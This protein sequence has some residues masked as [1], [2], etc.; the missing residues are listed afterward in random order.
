MSCELHAT[1]LSGGVIPQKTQT[2][3]V[4]S[5][6]ENQTVTPDEGYL[7]S[8]VAV[9]GMPT[10]TAS[11]TPTESAQTVTPSEGKLLSEVSVGAIPSQYHNTSDSDGEAGDLLRGKVMY[12]VNGRVVGT[13]DA[14]TPAP[15]EYPIGGSLS[16]RTLT[17][18]HFPETMQTPRILSMMFNGCENLTTVDNFPPVSDIP[19]QA[20]DS[21]KNLILTELP[22][23]V[24]RILASAFFDCKKITISTLPENLTS[25][26]INAFNGCERVSISEVPAG[27]IS[28]SNGAFSSCRGIRSLVFR[29][30][31][32]T[33]GSVAFSG[34][35]NCLLYDFT[36]CTSVP[37]L[38]NENAFN[39]I[40][41]N[42]KIV[43]P[44][45]LYTSWIGAE[46]WNTYA[47]YIV[48]ESDYNT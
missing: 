11:V 31:I 33:I 26:E 48:R 42:C 36:N 38:A 2:K 5:S 37:T 17:G 34:C 6:T 15:I 41:S 3:A 12:G 23:S 27:V 44:D 43:V 30:D 25:I 20:F 47:S 10:E 14:I 45:S 16:D 40:N 8:S 28:I 21:C 19:V 35:L 29:G 46:K 39:Y 9:A 7:L 32:T 13:L 24:T 22:S 1:L 18:Y 4:S